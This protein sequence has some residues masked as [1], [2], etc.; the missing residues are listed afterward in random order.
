MQVKQMAVYDIQM[1][2]CEYTNSC[3]DLACASVIF[4]LIY[5]LGH[6]ISRKIRQSLIL[7]CETH[8]ALLYILQINLISNALEQQGSLSMEVLLQ[9]GRHLFELVQFELLR[10]LF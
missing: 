3:F 9:L 7:L 1:S 4:F 10:Y 2:L 5:L 6:S 8:F